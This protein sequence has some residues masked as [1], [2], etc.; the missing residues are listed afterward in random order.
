[1]T[2]TDPSTT[3]GASDSD[4]SSDDGSPTCAGQCAPAVPAGWQGPVVL[5]AGDDP[6]DCPDEFPEVVHAAQHTGLVNGAATCDCECGD[7][8]GA[9]CGSATL[10]E[11]GNNCL[12][13][14]VGAE[15]HA[16]APNACTAIFIDG[17]E[18]SL[19]PGAL[20]VSSAS[21]TPQASESIA[22]PTWGN[23]L[24]SCEA[25]PVAGCDDGACIP[26]TPAEHTLCIWQDGAAACPA[27]PWTDVTT[28][29]ASFT[30]GREC[31]AC[32]C[33]A[34][35]GSCGGYAEL[36]NNDCGVIWNGD[37]SAGSCGDFPDTS[38]ATYVP[39]LEASCAPS[40]GA[41]QGSVTTSGTVTYCCM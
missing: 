32:T 7:A 21:C 26:E 3:E 23:D 40:G 9:V 8:G 29:Y 41:L 19:T 18:W 20:D 35:T 5:Y 16:L 39:D 38:H 14:V 11:E 6:P 2:T 37:L 36:A 15:T 28:T 24:R 30:D 13:A 10:R 34:P 12:M 33:G 1:M 25:A 4:D 17:G 27:G 31:S 22:T